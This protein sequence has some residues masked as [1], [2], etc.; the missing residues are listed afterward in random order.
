MT[1]IFMGIGVFRTYKD[2]DQYG[3]SGKTISVSGDVTCGHP[4]FGVVDLIF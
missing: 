4:Y 2:N 3:A 1:K